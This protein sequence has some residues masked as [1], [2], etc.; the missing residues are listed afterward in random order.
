MDKTTLNPSRAVMEA[1][2]SRF[3]AAWGRGDID[4]LMALM[5]DD[6]TYRTSSGL[7]FRGRQEVREGFARICRPSDPATDPPPPAAPHFFDNKCLSFFTLLLPAV[8][9]GLAMVEGVDIITFD[10]DGRIVA[11]DAYRKLG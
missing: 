5:A 9:G 2:L 6:P 3:S 1:T 11:K 7:T 4:G 10:G 8:G